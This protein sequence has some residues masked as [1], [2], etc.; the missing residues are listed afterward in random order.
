MSKLAI[1]AA[2][3]VCHLTFGAANACEGKNVLFEDQF[4]DDS[5]GWSITED[6]TEIKDGGLRITPRLNTSYTEDNPGF[7]F[8][9]ADI[10]ADIVLETSD[11]GNWGA[12]VFWFEDYDNYFIFQI[13]PKGF[14]DIQR[15][16]KGNWTRL[17]ADAQSPAIK[18][19]AGAA[20]TVRV[21]V[22]GNLLTFYIN[23]EK[24]RQLRGQAPKQQWRFGFM[25]GS[26]K[27]KRTTTVFKNVKI[28]DV[29]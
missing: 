9:D 7:Y 17:I 23:G 16:F 11:D 12:L 26:P 20:N 21:T 13:T 5:G 4:Q 6:R 14:Y 24:V 22:K 27:E 1:T 18:K 19:E 25:S 10:C 3:V 29:P 8:D 15:K 28:T 2:L